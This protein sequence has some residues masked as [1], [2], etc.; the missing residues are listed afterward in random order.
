MEISQELLEKTKN[1]KAVFFD[2]DDTLRLKDEQYMPESVKEVFARL[3]EKDL[4]TGIASGRAYPAIVQ[5]VRDLGAN[6]YVTLNGQYVQTPKEEEIYSN[7]IAFDVIEKTVEWA[8]K[9]GVELVFI[10][11]HASRITKWDSYAQ[12]CLVV[13][14]GDKLEE[15]PEFYKSHRIYQILTIG[16]D[17]KELALPFEI[18]KSVRLVKWHPYSNDVI[19]INGSKANGIE[20]V[21]QTL[22]LSA[23]NVLVFGDELNDREM[24]RYAEIAVAMG[25]ANEEVKVLADLVTKSVRE[26][27]IL[28]ALESLGI[29]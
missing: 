27:G 3:K 24:F 9:E 17:K 20:Q 12:E 8:K 15:D 7:P 19:P 5:E 10:A 25:N 13:V 26:D 14:F 28:Y 21:M 6:Y 1:I 11:S 16:D 29:I 2:I 22:G 4:I 18:A 23:E